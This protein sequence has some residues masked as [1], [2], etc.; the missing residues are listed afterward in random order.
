MH[1]IMYLALDLQNVTMFWTV[2]AWWK[3]GISDG[4]RKNGLD[5]DLLQM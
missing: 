5:F 1:Q 2:G 4:S 3:G